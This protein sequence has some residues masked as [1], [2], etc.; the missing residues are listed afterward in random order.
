MYSN[1]T[2]VK[3]VE[4]CCVILCDD[5]SL[6]HI[7]QKESDSSDGEVL[8]EYSQVPPLPS[9]TIECAKQ[10]CKSC[11]SGVDQAE[12]SAACLGLSLKTGPRS[13]EQP[14]C[15]PVASLH[16]GAVTFTADQQRTA[17]LTLIQSEHTLS[18]LKQLNSVQRA[19][20]PRTL[21]TLYHVC[22]ACSVGSSLQ[23]LLLA[24]AASC[25]YEFED[26]VQTLIDKVV[27]LQV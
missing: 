4:P 1:D 3:A 14:V 7:P 18:G 27:S 16:D 10:T 11:D 5:S 13:A 20:L 12:Q 23:E 15:M 21:Y 19:L 8:S 22:D 26:S 17:D 2:S 6:T 24:D 9:S 25:R